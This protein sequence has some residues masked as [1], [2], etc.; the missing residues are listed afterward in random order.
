MSVLD[1]AAVYRS[2]KHMS[3][4]WIVVGGVPWEWPSSIASFTT[5]KDARELMGRLTKRYPDVC[6]RIEKRA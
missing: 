3:K 4:T 1:V 6:F 2:D 5:E